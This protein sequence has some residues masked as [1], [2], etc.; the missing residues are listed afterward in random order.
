MQTS[1]YPEAE[2]NTLAGIMAD[3]A[4]ARVVR[5]P[6]LAWQEIGLIAGC[7]S[8]L[9]LGTALAIGG[10]L[11]Y[12]LAMMVN[13]LAIYAIFTPLHD[14]TH[15]A[16]S[17]NR[18]F[19]DALGTLAALPLFPGFTT[20][21]YR[22][23]HMEH[24]KHT[25]EAEA[26]P[27]E[28]TVAS[29]MP[30]KLLAWMFLDLYWI[31]WYLRRVGERPRQE[32]MG[33]IASVVFFLGWHIGW[34]LSPY[35][36]EFLLLW[37]I[38]QRLGITLLVYMFASIQH[39]E[40]VHQRDRPIQG[41]RMM[42]GGWWA[43]WATLSQAQH[44]M[45]HLFP[46]VPYYRYNDAWRVAAPRLREH[47]I[48]WGQLLGRQPH[49]GLPAQTSGS[50]AET[51]EAR[52]VAVEDVGEVVRAYT[53]EPAAS[54]PFPAYAPGA[55]VDVHLADGIVR[56][57]SLCEAFDG[58]HYRIAVK[59][60][61]RGRGGSRRLHAQWETGA[62]VHIGRP[63]N[64]FALGEHASVV[65][66]AGG[67]GITPLLAMADALHKA[68]TPFMFH[69]CAR[70]PEGQPFHQF[71][72]TAPYAAD[73]RCHY[74]HAP[75]TQ[76]N[77]LRDIDLPEWK[78][79]QALY[80]C[81]PKGFMAHVQAMASRRGWPADCIFTESFSAGSPPTGVN[82]AFE[83]VLARSGRVLQVGVAESLLDALNAAHCSVP[84]ACT[85]GLCGSCVCT[86]LKGDVEHRDVALTDAD[87]AAGRMTVCVSRARGARLVLDL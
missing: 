12:P 22:F 28:V 14:A 72:Q 73:V 34:L 65:L 13:A 51:M 31:G 39:P 56:Q 71:L 1:T 77:P 32:W 41:T 57:Y 54:T 47:D 35:A 69:V 79:G 11:P 30:T 4:F 38:P 27:D 10:W 68:R 85:Q 82:E 43:R 15:G 67:I 70:M 17:R 59:R 33:A 84:A 37:L 42:R 80:L 2:R 8:V 5:I 74:D 16:L 66:V 21:L 23:L 78:P 26:D 76:N 45:H 20:G 50:E 55:H 40:G 86:V 61:D 87:R 49:P 62:T 53:L 19:N 48:V 25:G 63:R 7:Y 18:T 36:V 60:E 75:E 52:V 58:R 83:A 44:L 46:T 24:H 29:R 81:G 9:L 6:T 3:P 64:L